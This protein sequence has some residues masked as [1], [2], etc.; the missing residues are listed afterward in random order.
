MDRGRRLWVDAICIDQANQAEKADQI[1]NMGHLSSSAGVVCVYFGEC[2]Y[3][4]VKEQEVL[5]HRDE[6]E[7]QLQDLET[8]KHDW[9]KGHELKTQIE[10]HTPVQDSIPTMYTCDKFQP[11][12]SVEDELLA[13]LMAEGNPQHSWWR[14]IWTVQEILLAKSAVVF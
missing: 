10:R 14:R 5:A 2:S 4:P 13:G 7:Q 12:Q 9:L 11:L 8:Q 3:H 6:L 1:A